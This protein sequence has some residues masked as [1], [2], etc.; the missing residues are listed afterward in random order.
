MLHTAINVRMLSI[1]DSGIENSILKLQSLVARCN[2]TNKIFC[3][4]TE[5]ERQSTRPLEHDTALNASAHCYPE[6]LTAKHNKLIFVKMHYRQNSVE[7]RPV[8]RIMP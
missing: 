4:D 6:L 5:E 8:H 1:R 2:K 3:H 7:N